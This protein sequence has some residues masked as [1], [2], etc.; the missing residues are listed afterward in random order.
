MSASLD[1]VNCNSLV[2]RQI[3]LDDE[4]LQQ[5][6]EEN[7]FFGSLYCLVNSI[8]GLEGKNF[9]EFVNIIE[10][11]F[12]AELSAFCS[13]VGIS[14]DEQSLNDMTLQQAPD[15]GFPLQFGD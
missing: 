14:V 7:Q 11:Q 5:I 8:I 1:L 4:Q 12:P 2:I 13:L 9:E 3:H 6:K 10:E 15:Q